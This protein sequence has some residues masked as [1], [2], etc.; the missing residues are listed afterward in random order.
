MG[1]LVPFLWC[2]AACLQLGVVRFGSSF[3]QEW[4]GDIKTDS[5]G[6]RKD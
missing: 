3:V 5:S 6:D 2:S 1:S 4:R